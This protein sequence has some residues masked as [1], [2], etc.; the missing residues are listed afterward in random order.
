MELPTAKLKQLELKT[1]YDSSIPPVLV[2][3]RYRLHR[4]LINLM[5]N[6]IKF[7]KKGHVTLRAL[8]C[9][10]TTHSA[11]IRFIIED[12]GIGIPDD[13]KEYIFETFSRL[14]L[15]NTGLYK[16]VGLGLRVVKQFM[17]EM[18]GEI[19]LVSD[20]GQGTQFICTIPFN[21]P[22]TNDFVEQ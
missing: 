4:I 16:G 5:S 3:D 8:L 19:D 15:S 9:N 17:H 21:I 22:L 20:V 6:A 18:D 2:G 12:T 11:L 10:K 13:K 7:T 14:T 1:H